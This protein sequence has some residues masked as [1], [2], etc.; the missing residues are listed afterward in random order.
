MLGHRLVVNQVEYATTRP[1]ENKMVRPLL[2][3]L[4]QMLSKLCN[5]IVNQFDFN[6][7]PSI[8]RI[9]GEFVKQ[10]IPPGF[11]LIPNFLF[12]DRRC[13]RGRYGDD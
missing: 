5:L 3:L 1:C 10:Q 12:I 2:P 6:R 4:D 7:Q 8:H 11:Q 9:L 13:L